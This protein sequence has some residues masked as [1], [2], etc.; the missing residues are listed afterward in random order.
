MIILLRIGEEKMTN[1]LPFP[2]KLN[3]K[4][5]LVERYFWNRFQ[6]SKIMDFLYNLH[7]TSMSLRSW[8]RILRARRLLRRR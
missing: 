5:S 3:D 4:S 7:N 6:Y 1:F 2:N 8:H